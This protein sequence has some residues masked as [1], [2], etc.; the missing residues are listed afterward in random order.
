MLTIWL[1]AIQQ[2]YPA[3]IIPIDEPDPAKAS[4][5]TSPANSSMAQAQHK[6]PLKQKRH[7]PAVAAAKVHKFLEQ[8]VGKRIR[9]LPSR[10]AEMMRREGLELSD[11][12][13][14]STR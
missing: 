5:H 4:D 12:V 2:T 11:S 14:N 10:L 6:I 13:R 1:Q 3:R 9:E 7:L 8:D